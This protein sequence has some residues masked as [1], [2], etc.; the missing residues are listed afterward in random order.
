MDKIHNHEV[1]GS[2]PAPATK[3]SGL[4]AAFCFGREREKTV[5]KSLLDNIF[6]VSLRRDYSMS[7]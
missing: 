5:P 7:C 3:Q 6:F 4:L 2:I 1:A